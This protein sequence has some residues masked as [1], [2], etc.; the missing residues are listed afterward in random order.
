M[1]GKVL[2]TRKS[3]RTGRILAKKLGVPYGDCVTRTEGAFDFIFRYGNTE[4]FDNPVKMIF[5]KGHDIILVSN[6]LKMRH[7]LIENYI[8]VPKVYDRESVEKNKEKINERELPLIARPVNHWK[9]RDFNLIHDYDEAMAY[10]RRGYYLQGLINKETEYRI[11]VW[12]GKIFECSVK[13]PRLERYDMLVR[14]FGNGWKFMYKQRV[15]TPQALR[16]SA[17]EAVALSGLDFGGV[18]CCIDKEGKNYIFEINSAPSLIDRK[19]EKLAKKVYEF[20]SE[21]NNPDMSDDED[22]EPEISDNFPPTTG[23]VERELRRLEVSE[24]SIESM[25]RERMRRHFL[26]R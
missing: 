7:R 10:L 26:Y 12:Q 16:K 2:G 19:A 8:P 11:F 5:N 23:Q 22:D 24:S 4:Q 3:Q 6:K 20:M 15:E 13:E 1:K 18:D 9:G 17:R 21:R 14:N 25:N